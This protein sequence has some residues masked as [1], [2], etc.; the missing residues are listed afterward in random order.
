MVTPDA[1]DAL[2]HRI[3]YYAV[4]ASEQIY[5]YDYDRLFI[6]SASHWLNPRAVFDKIPDGYDAETWYHN[7]VVALAFIKSYLPDKSVVFNGLHN[8]HGAEDS[9]ANTDGSMWETFAFRPQSG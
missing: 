4:T 7:R 5:Q 9:L 6:D 2:D 1:D 3:N 8:E